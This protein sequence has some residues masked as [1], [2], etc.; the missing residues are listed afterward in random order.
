MWEETGND[1]NTGRWGSLGAISETVYH[2]K[3][4]TKEKND[5]VWSVMLKQS[6]IDSDWQGAA[7]DTAKVVREGL[8]LTV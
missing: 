4:T 3:E 6:D 7:D 5:T 2:N 8:F 1:I